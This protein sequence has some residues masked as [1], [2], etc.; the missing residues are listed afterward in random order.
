MKNPVFFLIG[1]LVVRDLPEE[2]SN[3][4]RIAGGQAY[5]RHRSNLAETEDT[6]VSTESERVGQGCGNRNLA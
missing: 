4:S 1:T 6:I 5:Y 2:S 3:F